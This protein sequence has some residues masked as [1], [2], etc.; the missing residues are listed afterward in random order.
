MFACRDPT[1][2][3]TR[4][5]EVTVKAIVDGSLSARRPG[6]RFG[7]EGLTR[8]LLGPSGSGAACDLSLT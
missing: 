7:W 3:W 5:S 4:L 8:T 2:E 1:A 6:A